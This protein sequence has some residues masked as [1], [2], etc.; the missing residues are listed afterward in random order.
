M[1]MKRR[2]RL[3]TVLIVGMLATMNVTRSVVSAGAIG[4]PAETTVRE[5]TLTLPTYEEDLPDAN[6]RFDLFARRPFLIYPYT[7]RTNL[8]D[9]RADRT[10]RTLVLENEHLRLTVLPDLGGRIYSCVDKAN[11][12]EMFYA[13]TSIKYADVA[14]RGAW[15]A[16]GVEFNFPVSHNWVTVSPVDFGTVRH[17]DGSASVWVGNVDRPY[18]MQWRVELRLRPGRSLLEQTTTLYNRSDVRHR[19]YWWTAANVRTDGDS[20]I[21][22]P[23]EFSAAHHFADVDT[24][25]VDASGTDLRYPRN[26]TAGYVARFAHGTRE[27]FLGVYRPGTDA[28]MVHVAAPHDMPGKK[29]WSWGWDDEGKDWRR[30]LSDDQSAYLEPQAGLFRNQETYAFLDPQQVLRFGETWQPVRGIGGFSRANDEGVVHLRRGEGGPLRVGLNVTRAVRGGRLVVREGERAVSEEALSLGPSG[31]FDR[32]Y[33]GLTAPGPYTVEVRDESG[34]LLLTH[35][36]GRYDVVPR[37]EVKTGPQPAHVFP[38]AEKR[39]EGD[40][41]ELGRHQELNGKLLEAHD[42]YAAALAV[43]PASVELRRAAGRLS[44]GLRRYA[45]AVG[46]LSEAI[47]RRSNDAEALYY[48]GLAQA[49]LGETQK[50]R[51]AWDQAATAPAWRGPAILQ[52]ARLAAREGSELE[53]AHEARAYLE[54]DRAAAECRNSRPDPLTLVQ[55]A[56]AAAPGMIRAGGMEVALLRRTG[57]LEEAKTRLAHWRSIDP[58]SSF[59]RH[60]ATLLGAADEALWAHLAGDPERVLELVVDY[61]ALGL[62]DDAHALLARRYPST[63]VVAEPGT[64]LPQD[65]PL[66]S[67]Y[68]GYCAEKVGLSGAQDFT[69]ASRQ[70]TRYVFPN[71]AESAV[72]LR[73]ALEFNPKDAT[74]HLLLGSLFLAGGQTD[75]ALAE[76]ERA[77]LF[78]PRLPVLHRNIGFTLLYARGAA[79]EALRVFEEG[80][81]VDPTNV[82]LYQGADQALSLL[83]R[84]PE[85]RIAALRRYPG[86]PLPSTLVYKL[87][88]ALADAAR[89]AEAEALFP[90]RFFPREEFGTN[91]RQVY[92][93]VKLRQAFALAHEGRKAEAAALA[94]AFGR[95]VPGFDFTRDGMAAFVNAPR[96]QYYCGELQALLGSDAAAREHWR[97]AAAGRDFR[98]TALAHRAAQRLGEASD[99]EWRPR[100]E[101]A[102]GEAD[103]YLFR[104]GHYP[105][106]ATAARGML[107]RALGR[108][109]EGAAALRE[110]IVLPDRALAHHIARRALQEP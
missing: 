67:Y 23:M 16:L 99:A 68:R 32:T 49:A 90:G 58:P 81:G 25:P 92:L 46:P 110:V 22:Y 76:W 10:W 100:L 14:Y 20:R 95:P 31:V 28:G 65:Y 41:V 1:D 12:A 9:R 19:F 57:R 54:H 103:T 108:V 61:T 34:R 42:V 51:F 109:A 102:L 84:G 83:D 13:N 72:V 55:Q 59:L 82:E 33:V 5:S 43:F 50:A 7:A 24:W 27:P 45:E 37:A 60:E 98:Q 18:G 73:R 40:W 69:L 105:A 35:T 26:H 91:V 75:E 15:V 11:G 47:A 85:E 64:A 63:G 104:G 36:E 107:L 66:V 29:I 70:S 8:T 80:M 4:S 78:D 48:L 6:P 96:F 101:A 62:W 56:L 21:V 86:T 39:S 97:R 30:A 53:S 17:P 38:P 89:F 93:E 71:R 3:T 52:L 106:V 88:L 79:E 2:V 44:V 87:A 94:A 74:A 77:R